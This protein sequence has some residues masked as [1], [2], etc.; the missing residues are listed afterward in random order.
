MLAIVLVGCLL[1]LVIGLVLA[2]VSSA[3]LRDVIGGNFSRR[4]PNGPPIV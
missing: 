2:S 4:L 1:P 3:S